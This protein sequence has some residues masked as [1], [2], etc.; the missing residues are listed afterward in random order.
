MSRW[1]IKSVV[2][3]SHDGRKQQL[4]FVPGAVNIITG[5][6]NTG[7]SAI[8][9]TIDYCLGS[10]QCDIPAYIKDRTQCVAVKWTD[11][12]TE[13]LV[14]RLVPQPP[15]AS[16]SKMFVDFMSSVSIPETP[17]ELRGG[18]TVKQARLILE[19]AFGIGEAYQEID[20]RT[21][22]KPSR[23]SVR[24]IVPYIFLSKDVID[25][26]TLLFHGLNDINVAKHIIASIPFFLGAVDENEMA[27]DGQMR[28]LRA[29]IEYELRKQEQ[30]GKQQDEVVTKC[31]S[32]IGEAI[33]CGIIP[34]TDLN[35]E[36]EKLIPVLKEISLW[37]PTDVIVSDD[38]AMQNLNRQKAEV[39]ELLQ[40]LSRQR[41][42]AIQI[43]KSSETFSGVVDRQF[44]KI[45][46]NNFFDPNAESEICPVCSARVTEVTTTTE[47]IKQAFSEL[48][49]EREVVRTHRP[50]LGALVEGL[51]RKTDEARQRVRGIE[52]QIRGLVK[53]SE[54][55][56]QQ[57]D[58]NQ[59]GSHV[60]GRVSY[61]LDHFQELEDYD[62]GKLTELED[63]LAELEGNFSLSN[64]EERIDIAQTSIS[65]FA[66]EIF[67]CLPRG[68]PCDT[69]RVMFLAKKPDVL[70]YDHR[71]NR[72]I[73]FK[74]IGS[75]ENYLSL[76]EAIVFGLQRFFEEAKRPVPGVVIM[77]QVSRP[78]FSNEGDLDEMEVEDE[79][80][81]A[82]KKHFDFI[83][84]EV[85]E[86]NGLQ[87][88]VLEHAYFHK[89]ARYREAVKYRWTQ[90]NG[91]KLIPIDWPA[92]TNSPE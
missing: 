78:Y 34:T 35:H 46:V 3:Y 72:N 51:D 8:I 47:A 2:Y 85:E 61:F 22:E 90:Q 81:A 64:R 86:R 7:K 76:H 54:Y 73:R 25:S 5:A 38:A 26:E 18:T 10:S 88:I 50:V 53:E 71:S 9:K 70:I 57:T 60:A 58:S 29:R 19:R 74:E 69:G 52:E 6:S 91:E 49:R 21:A 4:D 82:L 77:D 41:K 16:M 17:E 28:A 14:S 12:T 75:D 39:G 48:Q 45:A 27:A 92:I 65:T 63:E 66:T 87:V 42:G 43:E 37:K 80:K 55:A 62:T 11:G 1:N 13:L 20:D 68:E 36:I 83:F 67:E 89:D 32:L 24:Q 15:Q 40:K 44:L 84:K 59:R 33:Q 23:I 30:F 31:Q 79:D 56:L